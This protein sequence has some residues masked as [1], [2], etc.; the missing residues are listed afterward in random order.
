MATPDVRER[1]RRSTRSF[2]HKWEAVQVELNGRYSVSRFKAL[3]EYIVTT[4]F[5]RALLMLPLAP[6]PSLLL[7]AFTDS[8]PLE[9]PALGLAHSGTAWV[10]AVFTAF[11]YTHCVVE[12]IRVYSPNLQLRRSA[13]FLVSIPTSIF[14]NVLAVALSALLW[15]PMPFVMP[16]L[17]GPWLGFMTLFLWI[18]RGARMRAHPEAVKDV[19]RFAT[20]CGS[21]ISMIVVYAIFNSAFTNMS[22]TYQPIFALLIPGFKIVQKNIL[23]RILTGRDDTKPQVVIFN[24]E[25]FNALF[26]STCMQNAQSIGTSIT[27]I[28]VDLLQALISLYDLGLMIN[29]V[30][31]ITDKLG[32]STNQAIAMAT[33]LLGRD[34]A[35]GTVNRRPTIDAGSSDDRKWAISSTP[36]LGRKAPK[37]TQVLPTTDVDHAKVEAQASQKQLLMNECA[38]G[39]ASFD[40]GSSRKLATLGPPCAVSAIDRLTARERQR[41]SA[42]ARQVL[43]L[44]EFLLLVEFTEV[45]IPLIYSASQQLSMFYPQLAHLT[46]DELWSRVGNVLTYGMLELGSLLVM[47]AVLYRTTHRH[48]VQQLAFVLEREFSMVQ[49]KLIL[50]VIMT[51]QSTLPHLERGFEFRRDHETLFHDVVLASRRSAQRCRFRPGVLA[52]SSSSSSP[53]PADARL[54]ERSKKK[55]ARALRALREDY[56]LSLE[57]AREALAYTNSLEDAL[58]FLALQHASDELPPSLRATPGVLL[59]SKDRDEDSG[60]LQATVHAP[61]RLQRVLEPPPAAEKVAQ[62]P[63]EPP[64]VAEHWDQEDGEQEEEA[65]RK[66]ADV[67]QTEALSWTQQYV[68]N[69]AAREEEQARREAEVT[70]EARELEELETRYNELQAALRRLKERKSK[71]KPRSGDKQKTRELNEQAQDVR[72]QLQVRGWRDPMQQQQ[73]QQQQQSKKPRKKE[74]QQPK[75]D[76]TAVVV[77][78]AAPPAPVDE[79]LSEADDELLSLALGLGGASEQAAVQSKQPIV[80]EE[81]PAEQQ[82]AVP[83]EAEGDAEE[84]DGGLFGLLEAAEATVVAADAIQKSSAV[85]TASVIAAQAAAQLTATTGKKGKG[86]K[87][88]KGRNLL[89]VQAAAAQSAQAQAAATA[90]WTGKSPRDH[91]E[92]QCRKNNLQKPQ[93]KKLARPAGGGHLYSVVLGNK[94]RGKQEV[95][96]RDAGDAA[97][98]FES[99]SEAKDAVATSALYELA[100]DLPLYRVLPP[101]YRDLWL[102]WVKEQQRDEEAAAAADRNEQDEL[103]DE[104]FDALPPEIAEKRAIIEIPAPQAQAA[105]IAT[106]DDWSVD[107]WDA[108]LSDEGGDAAQQVQEPASDEMPTTV[109]VPELEVEPESEGEREA[110]STLSLQLREQLEKRMRS[111]AYRSKLSQREALPIASFKAQVVAA[112]AQHDVLLISGETG[113]GKSTQVP[114]FLLEDLLFSETGGARGQIICTQPRRLAAISLAERV[115]QELGEPA[116]GSGDSLTGFQI[117]L[118]TRMTRRTRLL[119]CTTGILLRKLQDPHTL[120]EEVSHVIVDEVHERDLQSDVLLAMLRQFLAEGNA[121]RRR[122]F[123]G[124]LP[125]LKVVLMS[126]TLNAESFQRYFGGAAV[127]PMLEIPG[128][129][130]PVE[131]FYLEDVLERT[132]FV[133]DQESPAYVPLD[134]GNTARNSTQV[135]ISGRGGTSYTQQVTWTSSGASSSSSSKAAMTEKQRELEEQYSEATLRALE[136]LDPSVVNY[137]LI[138]A[139]VEHLITDTDLLALSS[140]SKGD[141]QHRNSSASVLVFLPGLQEITTLLDLLAG[142][143]ALR[144]DPQGREFELLPL[145]SSLS[146]QEQQRIFQRRPGV[147]RVIAATN[148]AETSLTIDDVKVVIDTGRVK[149]MRHDSQRRTNVL[150]EIWV[151]RANAKQ[152]AGRAGRTSGGSCFRL[153]PQSVFRSVMLEQPVPEIKRAPLASLCLQIK[154]FG[155]GGSGTDGCREFLGACLDPPDDASIRDALEELFEIGA[156]DREDEA[157]TTLGSHLTRLPVDVKVG[158]L[159]L[160]GALFGVFDAASTCAAILETKSPFVAPFGRQNEMKQAR[161]S[162]AVGA[163]DLLTDINAFEA[164]R[165][166]TQSRG[167]GGNASEKGFC[168]QYFLS[169]RSMRE[170]TKLKRQFRGLVVQLG[171]LPS[172]SA[173][174]PT[175]ERMTRQQL[176]T[177]AAVLYAGLSPNLVHAEPPPAHGAKRA[178]LRERDHAIVVVHPGSINHKVASFRAS[179]FLTYAVKLHTSQ[180]YLPASSLVLPLAVCLFGHALEPLP[181]LRRKDKDGNETIGLRVNDWVVFQSSFRSAA[182]LQEARGAVRDVIDASLQAPPHAHGNKAEGESESQKTEREALVNALRALFLAEYEERDPQQQLTGQLSANTSRSVA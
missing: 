106:L 56:G 34:S 90:P 116:M 48:P 175:D 50:W 46:D 25:I 29:D 11:L 58:A 145:H 111:S 133:V 110:A 87:N 138:Q 158:K 154:T 35:T 21:Q 40:G 130:F 174:S 16:L 31:S 117:R 155:A 80:K 23:S 181:Q 170:L 134:D 143:R 102:R 62:E 122:K 53:E 100:P 83:V 137:E 93:Y 108:D 54:Q 5:W 152:R 59:S 113:C 164:W 149:Q 45:L 163:S 139:L 28:I 39:S 55:L 104:I 12:Q 142:T 13:V 26:I 20:I 76:A 66:P 3:D 132:Q 147:V 112:L 81:Q 41:L 68:L 74:K 78:A 15:Y 101:A 146:A 141:G 153:F 179:N 44:T 77:D 79:P 98:G 128:R 121:A 115:S 114:Q 17:S 75:D 92:Q 65:E 124:T 159:L 7:V 49:P 95:T 27:L 86:G 91:L 60:E 6:L 10:R 70:P 8:L 18:I 89:K 129:T 63:L 105:Q 125:P 118:E 123:G 150:D 73:Q 42:K 22:S 176:A 14:T 172:S 57:L 37:K 4:S 2:V 72:R 144:R 69:M 61:V 94:A 47:V 173:S 148:I 9:D 64:Q 107:D 168:H 177:M 99:I 167:N 96:V 160:L 24:V 32:V 165:H 51:L 169:S 30:K 127:C 36:Q 33:D 171:F 97:Q 161:Q 1:L 182:L 136:C 38:P 103:L 85:D 131:Q 151:A 109:S 126:A 43:F 180:V 162:F 157:L 119:F 67:K 166:L 19:V 52:S 71:K 135:T 178:V 88:K 156:L 82:E 140:G 84:G 120:G